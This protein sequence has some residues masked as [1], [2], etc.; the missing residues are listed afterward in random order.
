MNFL[1]VILIGSP[2]VSLEAVDQAQSEGNIASFTCHATG[3]PAPVIRWY[4]K[5]ILV[6]ST[7][8]AK[9]QIA[10]SS[11]NA[12]TTGSTLTITNVKSSDVGTYICNAINTISN[13]DISSG[14]LTVN[15]EPSLQSN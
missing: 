9:Y 11:L 6:D 5:G 14:V 13:S 1:C 10:T 8:T 7:N 2:I 12:T 15:G 4:Y 3:E